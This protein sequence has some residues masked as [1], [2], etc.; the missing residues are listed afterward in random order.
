MQIGVE[1]G[2][3]RCDPAETNAVVERFIAAFNAGD[4]AVLD[5]VFA[6]EGRFRWYSV[7]APGERLRSESLR[8]STLVGYFAERHAR[9]E[10]LALRSWRFN[11]RRGSLGHF[12]FRLT[13]RATD[14]DPMPYAGKGAIDCGL[15]PRAIVVL[16]M[17]PER[18]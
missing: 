1:S 7:D 9:R 17:G 10:R 6:P 2:A 5:R 13:R 15:R 3:D 8:R 16:A 4:L 18:P 14:L 12:E 11:G